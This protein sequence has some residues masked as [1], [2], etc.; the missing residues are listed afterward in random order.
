MR[1]TD[2]PK[3]HNIRVRISSGMMT[4]LSQESSRR[5]ITV[6]SLIRDLVDDGLRKISQKES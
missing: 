4:R 3:E 5:S 2:D 6:S 1:P